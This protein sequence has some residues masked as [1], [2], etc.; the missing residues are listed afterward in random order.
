MFDLFEDLS[1]QT[2]WQLCRARP[3]LKKGESPC[4]SSLY[5][6]PI[7][8][9]SQFKVCWLAVRSKL[10][11]QIMHKASTRGLCESQLSRSDC[12]PGNKKEKGRGRI[13]NIHYLPHLSCG[14]H[15]SSLPQ[16]FPMQRFFSTRSH[17]YLKKKNSSSENVISN[18]LWIL[19]GQW[20]IWFFW[21]NLLYL[22]VLRLSWVVES[23]STLCSVSSQKK[24]T[25][26]SK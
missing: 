15:W 26:W 2:S 5:T 16:N 9:Q 23:L 8:P 13:Y 22:A 21:W 18:P 10:V 25:V 11:A 24:A 6:G 3:S 19:N 14:L 20:S 1:G 7:K 12:L 17:K 4:P